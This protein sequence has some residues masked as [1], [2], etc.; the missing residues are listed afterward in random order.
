MGKNYYCVRHA[1]HIKMYK[2]LLS[3]IDDENDDAQHASIR[4]KQKR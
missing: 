1:I 4:M 3:F 2:S